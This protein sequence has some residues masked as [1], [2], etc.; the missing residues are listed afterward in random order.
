MP[1]LT[2]I[3]L[4]PDIC[5]GKPCIRHMRWPVETILDL[6]ST[7]MGWDEILACLHYARLLVSGESLRRVA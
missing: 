3:T 2:R 5:H 1:D 4:D 7:G 6:V